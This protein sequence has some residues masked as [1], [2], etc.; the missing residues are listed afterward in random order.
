MKNSVILFVFMLS[1]FLFGCGRSGDSEMGTDNTIP[2]YNEWETIV[3]ATKETM[4]ID[5]DW[6][7]VTREG[8][9]KYYDE[10]GLAREIWD[11]VS[12]KKILFA[13]SH[14]S[15]KDTNIITMDSIK[16][17]LRDIEVYFQN[18]ST[19]MSLVIEDV[20]PVVSSYLPIEQMKEN[21]EIT[22]A[23]IAVPKDGKDADTHYF[24][25][26]IVF[27]ESR[28]SDPELFYDVVIEIVVSDGYV[29]MFRVFDRF[30]N[31]A[32]RLDFN[33][34]TKEIW[35]YDFLAE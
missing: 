29:Q 9:P 22:K 21:Y 4:P 34:Y 8:H 15:Y 30:P 16:G 23:F 33:G 5:K 25:Q 12:E 14:K 19:P 1:L 20:L 31:W 3:E 7:I 13:D 10:E 28:E 18:F 17:R 11:D 32:N 27:D 26:Y 35:D 24:M 2:T 6:E